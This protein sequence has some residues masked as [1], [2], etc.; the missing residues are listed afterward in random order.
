M[1]KKYRLSFEFTVDVKEEVEGIG[2]AKEI[3]YM[4]EFIDAFN[5]DTESLDEYY[6]QRIIG[7]LFN[8][9]YGELKD[10][11]RLKDEKELFEPVLKKI[12]KPAAEYFLSHFLSSTDI[13]ISREDVDRFTDLI[14][15]HYYPGD[16]ITGITFESLP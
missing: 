4:Q 12:S 6:K 16:D 9:S 5:K 11:T 15:Q 13:N 8:F 2:T 3:R 7:R 10:F 1:E 14:I